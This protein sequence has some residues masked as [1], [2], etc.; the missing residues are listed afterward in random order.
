MKNIIR[1]DKYKSSNIDWIGE[2]PEHWEI[3][4]L[5]YL[6]KVITGKKDTKD[7]ND[8]GKYP[9]FVRSQIVE[10]IPTYSYDCEAI[11]TAGDGVG[12]GRVVHY[13]YGK[14]N[15]HQRVYMFYEFKGIF[16]KYLYYYIKDSLKKELFKWN[17]KSTVDSLR[18][19]FFSNFP[20]C[21]FT[22]AEQRQIANFLDKKTAL[23]DEFITKK[24][25]LIELFNKQKKGIITKA[26]TK[27]I[28]PKAKMKDSG[29]EWIGEIPEQWDVIRFKY[30][31]KVINGQDQK[32]VNDDNGKYPI[33]GSGGV[34]G[35]SN[36]FLYSKKSVLLGRKGTI[37][38]PLFVTEPFWAVDTMFY[39]KIKELVI[40]EYFF[41]LCRTINFDNY[42]SGSAI[43]SMTQEAFSNIIF[44]IPPKKKQSIFLKYIDNKLSKIDNVIYKT[45]KETELMEKYRT[46][47][48]SEVITGKIK[49]T[50]KNN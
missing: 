9:F 36:N 22:L 32:T 45:E 18:L 30:L 1:Y 17:A 19:P 29:V 8:N 2:I 24:K 34:F 15:F 5:K 49:V 41:L 35:R 27:G 6:C 14:F 21:C 12:V 39:T 38:K 42:K 26:V 4:K 47:L 48:I 11:L 46:A 13:I 3:R 28:N 44:A 16:A 40:P 7:R 50:D 33:Y 31:A 25:R 20:V 10:R 43:P 37:D 23:I